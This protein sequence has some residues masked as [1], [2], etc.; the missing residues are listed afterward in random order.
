MTT[1]RDYLTVSDLSRYPVFL[2]HGASQLERGEPIR[3]TARALS[4]YFAALVIRTASHEEAG[5]LFFR[6]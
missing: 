1:K 4:R 2:S 5:F 3:D 6:R